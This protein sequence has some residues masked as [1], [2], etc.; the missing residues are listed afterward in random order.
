MSY[1]AAGWTLH[2]VLG[3]S[4]A[5]KNVRIFV[6]HPAESHAGPN[7][8]VYRELSWM[9]MSGIQSDCFDNFAEVILVLS[10][11][12]NYYF[13]IN[14]RSALLASKIVHLRHVSTDSIYIN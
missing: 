5:D 9:N 6:N 3:P 1:H 10:G 13:T 2:F 7:R 8:H 12:F 4:L 11:S 14:G